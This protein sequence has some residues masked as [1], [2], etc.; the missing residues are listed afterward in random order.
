MS[1]PQ[2][3]G[4]YVGNY[5]LLGRMLVDRRKC[6][7]KFEDYYAKY[8]KHMGL[9]RYDMQVLSPFLYTCDPLT[10]LERLEP[11]TSK[12]DSKC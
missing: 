3:N 10:G 2:S 8:F 5:T 4:L 6:I 7:I 9:Q 12:K 1:S 11:L